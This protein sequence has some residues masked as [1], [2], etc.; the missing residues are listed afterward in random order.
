MAET[1]GPAKYTV[2]V[3]L[4]RNLGAKLKL[5]PSEGNTDIAIVEHTLAPGKLAAPLHR[6]SRE[7]EISY[8]LDGRMAVQD[9]EDVAVFES[10][11]VAVKPRGNWH[12]FWNPGPDHLRFLEIITPGQFAW[13]F[14]EAAD[15]LPQDGQPD[16]E[17]AQ[18]FA[19]LHEKYDFEIDPDSVPELIERHD[20]EL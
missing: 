2:Q 14:P 12:T 3:G 8:I 5:A 13:Y 4:G 11:D 9:G 10:G 18:Q 16:E 19:A 6:H 1:N 15:L 17:T 7:D 20:L